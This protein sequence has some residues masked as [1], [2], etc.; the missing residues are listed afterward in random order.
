MGGKPV[1]ETQA[2]NRDEDP[3]GTA[4]GGVPEQRR[5]SPTWRNRLGSPEA[6]SAG[7]FWDSGSPERTRSPWNRALPI[8]S[9]PSL[10]TS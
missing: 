5:A 10:V 1:R 2:R 6:I 7:R 4:R 3:G 9:V 8:P